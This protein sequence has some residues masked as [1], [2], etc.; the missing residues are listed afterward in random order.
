MDLAISPKKKESVLVEGTV[1]IKDQVNMSMETLSL[2]P[3]EGPT[4][5]PAIAIVTIC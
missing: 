3:L 2:Y 4:L 1:M 5:Q